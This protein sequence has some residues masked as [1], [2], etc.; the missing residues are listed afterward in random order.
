MHI[1]LGIGIG[2]TLIKNTIKDNLEKKFKK[3]KPEYFTWLAFL[4]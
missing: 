3:N 2:K 4:S 1:D